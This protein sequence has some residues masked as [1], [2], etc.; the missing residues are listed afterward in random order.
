LGARRAGAKAR[1]LSRKMSG[2]TTGRSWKE[3]ERERER[4]RE[5]VCVYV[6]MCVYVC[7]C[8]CMCVCVYVH[9][10]VHVC[11]RVHVCVH[12]CVCVCACVCV[13]VC[14]CARTVHPPASKAFSIPIFDA[15]WQNFSKVS[16]L[17]HLPCQIMI[18]LTFEK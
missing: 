17:L 3:T 2:V 11:V 18:G 4:E 16:S 12:V 13:R 15:L 6:Y 1:A 14:A 9:T 8:V 7:V 5:C 10:F